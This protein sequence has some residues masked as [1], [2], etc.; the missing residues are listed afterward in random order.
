MRPTAQRDRLSRIH[1][2]PARTAPGA[3]GPVQSGRP[4]EQARRGRKAQFRRRRITLASIV[5]IFVWLIALI[6]SGSPTAKLFHASAPVVH[7]TSLVKATTVVPGALGPIA[8]PA[9]GE[10][11]VAVLGSGLMAHS[12]HQPIVPIAS[13]TKMMTAMVV[14]HDHPLE[15]AQ[16]GPSFTMTTADVAAWVNADSTGESNVGIKN[17]EVLDEF[18]MLEAL[19]IPSADNIADYLAR[20]DAGS[21]PAFAVRMNK[22][23]KSLGLVNTHYADASGINPASRSTAADQTIVA[24]HVM[25]D[26][27]IRSI[28]RL[29]SIP[30]QVNGTVWNYN[31]ALGTDGIVGVKSGFTSQAGACLATAAYRTVKGKSALVITVALGQPYSL[32]AAASADRAMLD[33][34]TPKLEVWRPTFSA[35]TLAKAEV[36]SAVTPLALGG[37]APRILAWPGLKLD[38]AVVPVPHT[39]R[40]AGRPYV[41]E[42]QLSNEIGVVALVPLVATTSPQATTDTTVLRA[43]SRISSSGNGSPTSAVAPSGTKRGG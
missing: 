15:P 39:R 2:A 25:E 27:V 16:G 7:L 30:F 28:V 5:G 38:V 32:V 6:F 17:G 40:N 34:V 9:Q 13:V 37:H 8:W 3:P 11:A 14:L 31:P 35:A 43:A 22:M 24:A 23:A 18:Q 26:P 19:L 36:G 33:S 21:I 41:A 42:L 12:P 29:S 4:L 10:G 1:S 20:W